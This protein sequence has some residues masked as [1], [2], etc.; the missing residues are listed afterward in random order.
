STSLPHPTDLKLTMFRQGEFTTVLH[1]KL[2]VHFGGTGDV[3]AAHFIKYAFLEAGN[4]YDSMNRAAQKTLEI[5]EHSFEK[6]SPD[7]LIEPKV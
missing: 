7:L 2:E 1:K 4:L 5:I 6:K 3:F